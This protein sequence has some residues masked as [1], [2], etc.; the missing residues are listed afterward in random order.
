M[1]HA[2]LT[3]IDLGSNSIGHDGAKVLAKV[4]EQMSMQIYI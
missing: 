4:H 1:E 3:H 2:S